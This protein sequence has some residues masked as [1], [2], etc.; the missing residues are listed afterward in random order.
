[1]DLAAGSRQLWALMEHTTKDGRPRLVQRCNYPLTASGVVKRVYTN[2]AVL[3]IT[4]RGFEVLD[5][6]P[7]LTFDALQSKT[8]AK[9]Q[10]AARQ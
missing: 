1:M 9:L 10:M 4:Q 3:D 8:E 5:M 6:A 7:G 2:L